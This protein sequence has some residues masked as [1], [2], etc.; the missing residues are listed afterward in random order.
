[1]FKVK[2]AETSIKLC[3]VL[4]CRSYMVMFVTPG[5]ATFCLW[6]PTYLIYLTINHIAPQ[7]P[8]FALFYLLL[9]AVGV[10]FHEIKFWLLNTG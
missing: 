4:M 10:H 2:R 5:S 8:K 9:I 1:M 3:E 6:L 7:I